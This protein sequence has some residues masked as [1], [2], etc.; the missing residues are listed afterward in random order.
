MVMNPNLR[1]CQ[2]LAMSYAANRKAIN[3]STAYSQALLTVLHYLATPSKGIPA[4][5]MASRT[6]DGTS[7]AANSSKAWISI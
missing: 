4:S 2:S 6:Q 1:G 3:N 7:P 5:T